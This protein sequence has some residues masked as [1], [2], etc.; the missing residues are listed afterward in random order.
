ML[1]LVASVAFKLF[2]VQFGSYQ[3]T[4]GAIGGVIVV[5]LWFYFS[6]LSVLLGAQLN[7]TI[8]HASAEIPPTA[9]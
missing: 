1:W 6:C 7:A 5:L 8:A 9:A 2:V 4:Y 3:K